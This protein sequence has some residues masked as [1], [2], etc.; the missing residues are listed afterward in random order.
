M[1]EFVGCELK[2]SD[3]KYILEFYAG[4][5]ANIIIGDLNDE[6]MEKFNILD[7]CVVDEDGNPNREPMDDYEHGSIVVQ[8]DCVNYTINILQIHNRYYRKYDYYLCLEYMMKSGR[9]GVM[10]D[11]HERKIDDIVRQQNILSHLF[12]QWNYQY[13]VATSYS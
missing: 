9:G 2:E 3:I 10:L 12:P 13:I 7:D 5:N 1:H 11:K 4:L 8:V 6:L